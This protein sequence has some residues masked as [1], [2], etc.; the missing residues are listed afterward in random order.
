MITTSEAEPVV[1]NPESVVSNAEPVALN[2]A[3]STTGIEK[4]LESSEPEDAGDSI[5]MP[6]ARPV[7][8]A[9]EDSASG[10]DSMGE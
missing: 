5:E 1:P 10:A 2:V 6:G 7:W 4:R 9:A 8:G 3:L